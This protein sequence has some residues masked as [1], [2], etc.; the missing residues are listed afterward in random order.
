MFLV[1]NVLQLVFS[2][3]CLQDPRFLKGSRDSKYT[4]R[5]KYC[6]TKDGL[7]PTVVELLPDYLLLLVH[8]ESARKEHWFHVLDAS[9]TIVHH[10]KTNAKK[11]S[12]FASNLIERNLSCANRW[13]F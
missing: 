4:T 12:V 11:F 9:N 8:S 1:L 10:V 3:K 2:Q 7:V 6:K 13:A 5:E